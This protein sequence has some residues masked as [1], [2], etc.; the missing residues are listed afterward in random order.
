MSS[1]GRNVPADYEPPAGAEEGYED[2]LEAQA[3]AYMRDNGISDGVLFHTGTYTCGACDE[4][5]P[6]MLP[7]NSEL[8]IYYY[9]R[10][11]KLQY[12]NYVSSN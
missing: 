7:R 9:D 11:G 1:G 12:R 4:T 3:A 8:H 2:H 5:L 6:E 10:S